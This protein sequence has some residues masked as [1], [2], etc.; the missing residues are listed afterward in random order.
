MARFPLL[1]ALVLSLAFAG[2]ALATG[3]E[4]LDD[5]GAGA[6]LA[7]E[8]EDGDDYFDGDE[9]VEDDEGLESGESDE[10][11]R[12]EDLRDDELYED[13][14]F[15]ARTATDD[16][17][18]DGP[19]ADLENDSDPVTAPR[20]PRGTRGDDRLVGTERRDRLSGRR[21]ND[22][23]DGRG[24]ADFLNGG[25]GDDEIVTGTAAKARATA[26]AKG[27]RVLGGP[28]ADVIRARNGAR[29][30]VDCGRG[31]DTVLA[32][33]VDRVGKS[34]ESVKYR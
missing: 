32:E 11:L 9:A 8:L 14:L 15:R 1:L 10:D 24:A 23:L 25:P 20:K 30:R 16:D 33:A 28:G 22:F 34:C 2:T 12:D 13:E 31:R 3:G 4:D 27:D 18:C 19:M 7:D 21:G 26:R 29:D 17:G 5:D 6:C